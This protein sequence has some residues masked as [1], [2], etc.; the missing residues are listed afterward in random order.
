MFAISKHYSRT[1][2]QW[3]TCSECYPSVYI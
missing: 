1:W 3:F 2:S